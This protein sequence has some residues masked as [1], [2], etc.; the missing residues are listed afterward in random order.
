MRSGSVRSLLVIAPHP[1]DEAIGAFGLMARL[2]R[3]GLTVRVLVVSDGGASHPG[4]TT[5]PRER[6]VRERQR[7]TRRVMRRI[8]VTS[9]DITFLNLPDGE[10]GQADDIVRQRIAVCARHMR[11]PSLIVGPVQDDA[12]LDHRVVAVGLAACRV[13][14]T[15]RLAYAVWPAGRRQGRP[16]SALLLTA[17]EQRAKRHAIRSYKTQTGRITDDPSGFSMT[18]AQVVA[19]S[20]PSETFQELRR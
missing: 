7:E 15:R 10:L 5:W 17:A 19:F 4:S 18:D 3:R 16:S 12:H 11:K 9:S 6:L 1:D 14:G 13:P 20:R 2:R 8:G